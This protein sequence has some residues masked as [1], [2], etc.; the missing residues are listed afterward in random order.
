LA[1]DASDANALV[2]RA[3]AVQENNDFAE[4]QR[5]LHEA[6]RAAPGNHIVLHKLALNIKEQGRFAEAEAV[7][8]RVLEMTPN[9]AHALFDLSELE[10]RAGRYAQGWLDYE[11]RVVFAQ[12]ANSAKSALEAI[13][14]N[15][16]SESL[17]GKT[18]IVY[19][20]Q[21]NGDCLWA[22]RFLSLLA[23]RAQQE[24]GRVVFGYA[25]PMQHLFERMLPAGVVIETSLDTKPDFHCGLM[26]LPLR[27]GINDPSPWGRPYLGADPARVDAWRER[28]ERATKAGNRRVGLVWNGNP[29]HIRDARRSV[30][31]D[32]LAPLLRVPGITFFAVSPGREATVNQWR[33]QG[34]DVVDL[35]PQFEAG[36]DDVA[37]LLVNLDMLVTID[38]GPAHLAG[39]LGVPTLLM[40]DHVSA[41]FWGDETE[42]TPW[43]QTV[44]LFRQ[45]SVGEW[46][47]VVER[48]RARLEALAA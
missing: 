38:S 24:G 35:T 41:W 4:A 8:R 27:L 6:A 28:V 9:N 43:Y 23:E 45:P 22:V 20:E 1:R 29:G 40:L 12:D 2:W 10:M 26:S 31:A 36:F 13:S 30:P 47:P 17:A 21:G 32:R 46:S 37:A 15:W 42:R 3:A 5:L 11:A 19:G 44:E 14:S 34:V 25:G 16:R 33:G 48:V 39:A 18:L 7:L